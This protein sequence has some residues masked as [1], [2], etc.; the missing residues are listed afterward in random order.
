MK[1]RL[2]KT[3]KTQGENQQTHTLFNNHILILTCQKMKRH[4][5]ISKKAKTQV[6]Q[7]SKKHTK[8]GIEEQG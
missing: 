5:A 1:Q 4:K 2:K 3:E 7:K 8:G 6:N